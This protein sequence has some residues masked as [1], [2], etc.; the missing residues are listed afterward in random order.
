MIPKE[1]RIEIYRNMLNILNE[2]ED[3]KER[4]VLGVGL[5]YL[6]RDALKFRG[7]TNIINIINITNYP[8]LMRHKPDVYWSDSDYW[9][10]PGTQ[11][12]TNKRRK[13]LEEAID[14][15]IED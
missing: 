7:L 4:G 14:N 9:F 12:G 1:E 13:I 6:L 3:V 10:N 2:D 5:C 8:E 15:P 11:Q